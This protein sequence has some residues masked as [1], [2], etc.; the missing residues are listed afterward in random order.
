M[1]TIHVTPE[2]GWAMLVSVCIILVY[3]IAS[4]LR[5]RRAAQREALREIARLRAQHVA[6]TPQWESNVTKR[7][8]H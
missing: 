5:R 4:T 3:S 6:L 1:S 8:V 2:L 7:S